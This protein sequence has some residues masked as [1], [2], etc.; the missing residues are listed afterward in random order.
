MPTDHS[1]GGPWKLDEHRQR[2][3]F[4]YGLARFVRKTFQPESILEFGCGPGMYCEYYAMTGVDLVHGVEPNPMDS[5]LFDIGENCKFFPFDITREEIPAEIQ[6]TRY[7]L[8]MS[9]EVLEHIDRDYHDLVFDFF[10]EK[11][12]RVI[13]F[14]GARP[15]QKGTGHIACRDESD[16]RSEFVKR[17]W[18]FDA[19]M[20]QAI[21][22]ESDRKN[23]NHKK[24]LQ[25]FL[26]NKP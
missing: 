12:T 25:V 9:V 19:G 16:W 17:G 13:V 15:D 1:Q 22:D 8:I 10:C 11:S 4:N 7:D 24:N 23:I 20:T 6:A 26:R 2:F 21:R 14:S 5:K 18:H 3:T